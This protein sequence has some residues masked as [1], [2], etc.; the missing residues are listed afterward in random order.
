MTEKQDIAFLFKGLAIVFL[1]AC[2]T[3]VSLVIDHDSQNAR[4]SALEER[5]AFLENDYNGSIHAVGKAI[6]NLEQGASWEC[7]EWKNETV[8][9]DPCTKDGFFIHNPPDVP[10][11]DGLFERC[12]YPPL[13]ENC[14]FNAGDVGSCFSWTNDT[15]QGARD[16]FAQNCI[17]EKS[18][19][20]KEV[21]SRRN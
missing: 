17:V 3:F 14:E 8:V 12:F 20:V 5:Q 6:L 21:L 13:N 2:I 18:V 10:N 9:L 4:I 15:V 11:A 7:V 1:F 16:Y 19:C